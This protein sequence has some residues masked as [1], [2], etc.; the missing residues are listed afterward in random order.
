MVASRMAESFG[1]DVVELVVRQYG[2]KLRR[3]TEARALRMTTAGQL[4]TTGSGVTG[5]RHTYYGQPADP[6]G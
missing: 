5:G 4:T 3:D 2:D 6:R 1:Q